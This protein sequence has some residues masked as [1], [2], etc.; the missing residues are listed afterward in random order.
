VTSI[1]AVNE[2]VAVI[3]RLSRLPKTKNGEQQLSEV[4]IQEIIA[5]ISQRVAESSQHANFF[6]V[7]LDHAIVANSRELIAATHV[8][9]AD[10]LHVYTGWVYDC[11]YFI[12][13]DAK[14]VNRIKNSQ[15]CTEM[16]IIDLADQTDCTNL[17]STFML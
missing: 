7:P 1:W 13:H 3:D 12:V 10:A 8:S 2:I 5:T 17:R 9:A 14:I 6:F 4:E 15:L 16:T 11:D